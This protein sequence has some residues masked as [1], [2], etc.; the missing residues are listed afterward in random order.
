MQV[1]RLP[2][3]FLDLTALVKQWLYQT[4]LVKR[5]LRVNVT[6]IDE[7]GEPVTWEAEGSLKTWSWVVFTCW[8]G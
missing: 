8:F 3:Y 6:G 7:F 5:W 1:L 2:S 4:A